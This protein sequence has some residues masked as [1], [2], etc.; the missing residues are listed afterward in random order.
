MRLG[1][2]L[3]TGLIY[4]FLATPLSAYPDRAEAQPVADTRRI[5]VF[6]PGSAS[7]TDSSL[8]CS[9]RSARGFAIWAGSKA[10]TS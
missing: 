2:A 8:S 6:V 4:V 10:K 3:I 5:G 1:G 7:G 9:K